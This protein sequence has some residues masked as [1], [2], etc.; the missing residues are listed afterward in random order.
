[1]N[2]KVELILYCFHSQNLD[3]TQSIFTT[4]LVDSLT[5][6][7]EVVDQLKVTSADQVLGLVEAA[8]P[9]SISTY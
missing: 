3:Q 7:F 6:I 4:A 2:R 5:I 9:L 1:M 8:F